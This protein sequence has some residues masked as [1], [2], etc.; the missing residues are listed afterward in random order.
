MAVSLLN[1]IFF[2]K[3]PQIQLIQCVR[4]SSLHIHSQSF[5]LQTSFFFC[6]IYSSHFTLLQFLLNVEH[7]GKAFIF[8]DHIETRARPCTHSR[9]TNTNKKKDDDDM[10]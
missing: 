1:G 8:L 4:L 7:A 2:H 5:F 6:F 9:R 3:N 10:V